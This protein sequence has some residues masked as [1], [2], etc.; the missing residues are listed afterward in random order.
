MRTV[1]YLRTATIFCLYWSGIGATGRKNSPPKN[2]DNR[3]VDMMKFKLALG[4]AL[5]ASAVGAQAADAHAPHWEYKGKHGPQAWSEVDPSF[6][7]CK[8]GHEQSPIDIHGAHKANLAPLALDYHGSAAEVVNNGHTVQVNLSEGGSLT[9][10][11]VAYKLVQFHFHTP[12]EEHINGKAYP[13][14]AHM[15]HKSEDGKLAVIGV[16]LKEGKENA[17]LKPVF[18]GLPATEGAKVALERAF[19]AKLLLPSDHGYY[20]FA[21]SLTTPPCSEGVRWQIMKNPVEISHAQLKAFQKLYKANA[22]PI[23]PL[24][25][26]SVE[27]S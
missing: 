7:A 12:S 18:D 4:A 19:D 16:L 3:V 1:K 20:K 24:Y 22:R 2:I 5:L 10:D 8:L 17:A 6:S 26:R 27:E 23:Q 11:G 25:T 13:M 14:V 15:V 9:L 21:G